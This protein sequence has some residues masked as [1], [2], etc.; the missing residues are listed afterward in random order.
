MPADPVARAL[1]LKAGAKVPNTTSADAG[2]TLVVNNE[3]S[4]VAGSVVNASISVNDHTL[5][6]TLGE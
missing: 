5:E 4:V 6:I 2:K 1:A 3:G